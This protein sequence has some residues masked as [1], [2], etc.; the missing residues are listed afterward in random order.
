MKGEWKGEGSQM[1]PIKTENAMISSHLKEKKK[2]TFHQ[3][4][5]YVQNRLFID[6]ND[7][8]FNYVI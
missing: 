2:M 4:D 5:K 8:R 3:W 7:P 6:V 1:P